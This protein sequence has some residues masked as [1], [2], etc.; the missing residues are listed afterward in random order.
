MGCDLKPFE[1]IQRALVH[2]YGLGCVSPRLHVLFDTNG[3]RHA[4]TGHLV[5]GIAGDFGFGLLIRQ[6]PGLKTPADDGLVAVHRRLD[7][8]APAIARATLP[9]DMA[10]VLDRA[11]M[12]IALRGTGLTENGC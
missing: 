8:A 5:E 6:S 9:S 11:K 7:E 10:V 3:D 1:A 12:V 2:E 4:E